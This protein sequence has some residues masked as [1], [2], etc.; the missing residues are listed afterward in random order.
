MPAYRH[1]CQSAS[2]APLTV[3]L[4]GGRAPVNASL[5]GSLLSPLI[6]ALRTFHTQN[7]TATSVKRLRVTSRRRDEYWERSAAVS[8]CAVSAIVYLGLMDMTP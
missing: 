7:K 1:T 3:E 5:F 4:V 6:A 2:A 8:P